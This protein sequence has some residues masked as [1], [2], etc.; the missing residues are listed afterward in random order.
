M[1]K[2]VFIL[3]AIC[4]L[5]KASAQ[6]GIGTTTP[7]NKFEVVTSTADP[8]NSG[9][10]ANGNLRLGPSTGSHVLDF[11][12]SS[13]STFSWIQAR[14]KT[15]YGTNYMLALNPNGG[16]VGV[17]TTSPITTLTVGNFTGT[18][19]GEILLYPQNTTYEGGQVTIKKSLTGSTLDWTV[20]QYG[21][22]A[23][24][25]RLRIFSGNT[26]TNGLAILEN[27]NVG[28]KNIAPTKA[29]D[30]TGDVGVSGNLTGG[31][32]AS[33]TLAGFASVMNDQTGTTYTLTSADN[34]KIITLNN[35]SAIT[36]IVPSLSV[37]FNC[38]IVQK[39]SGQV[40]L[41]ASGVTISNRY[42]FTKTAGQYSILT[43]VCIASGVYISS[44]DMTN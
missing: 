15:A 39:G 4:A 11:G 19:S 9:A 16:Y 8:A 5:V 6:T 40:T 27:G 41:S 7:V 24:N 23:A 43:L 35:A 42:N 18:V 12:L 26:E 34:G 3:F 10:T 36:V 29:L 30:I 37:G 22:T 32:T 20:D 38:M 2:V 31:N 21:T 28:I 44:G 1:K 17:G 25:A 33:S 14:S 13:T